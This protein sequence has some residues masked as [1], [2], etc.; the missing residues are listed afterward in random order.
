MK[1]KEPYTIFKRTFPSGTKIYYYRTYDQ[2]GRRTTAKSTGKTSR[3]QAMQYCQELIGKGHL[4]PDKEITFAAFSKDWWI[5]DKCNYIKGKLARSPKN[6]PSISQTYVDACRSKLDNHILP[7]LGRKRL[8]QLT[9]PVIDRWLFQLREES[10]PK[11]VNNILSVFRIMITEAVRQRLIS[12][13]PMISIKPF[14]DD[15][16]ERG[17]LTIEEVRSVLNPT[18]WQNNIHYAMNLLAASTGMRQGEIR[19]LLNEHYHGHYI[20]VCHSYDKYGLKN[21]KTNE[22]RD[23][24]IPSR[25]RNVIDEINPGTGF[26]F[27]FTAGKTGAHGQKTTEALYTALEKIEIKEKERKE[28]NITFHSWRHFFN[29]FLRAANL[30]DAKVQ[31][32]IGH[33]TQAMTENYTK[34]KM[35]DYREV[36]EVQ[37]E[38]F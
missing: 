15:P 36:I 18:N 12:Y 26:V 28:R 1:Y 33:K 10:S 20:H 19:G 27:S 6:K 31:A 24:P 16:K 9:V 23:I 21:T 14:I 30:T 4:I 7:Y 17:V 13:N 32:I 22:V 11:T 5:W 29:T 38:L 37:K 2:D 8:D 34:F 3:G 35:D 25:V